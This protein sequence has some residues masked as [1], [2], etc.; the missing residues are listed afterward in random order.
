MNCS[1]KLPM[2]IML[3]T[4][5]IVIAGCGDYSNVGGGGVS[6]LERHITLQDGRDITCLTMYGNGIDC[7]WRAEA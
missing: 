3:I 2:M 6:V 7:D 4:L 5:A 1:D